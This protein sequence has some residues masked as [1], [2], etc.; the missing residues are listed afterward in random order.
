MEYYL[1]LIAHKI[2]EYNVPLALMLIGGA[3]GYRLLIAFVPI[4]A[5]KART[6]MSAERDRIASLERQ[7]S[8][9][10]ALL[11]NHLSGVTPILAQLRLDTG[12]IAQSMDAAHTKLDTADTMHGCL[13]TD[14]DLLIDR[15]KNL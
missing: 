11:A 10:D 8:E 9:K 1:G 3:Y 4:W 7:I 13:R 14:V 5:E 12:S 2:S 15:T 6:R